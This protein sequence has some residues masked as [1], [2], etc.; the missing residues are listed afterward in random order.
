MFMTS[1]GVGV[2]SDEPAEF[3][4]GAA[5]DGDETGADAEFGKGRTAL[6]LGALFGSSEGE[7]IALPQPKS[8]AALTKTRPVDAERDLMLS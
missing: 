4:L 8:S 1:A 7:L 6:T 3:T 5:A 2:S